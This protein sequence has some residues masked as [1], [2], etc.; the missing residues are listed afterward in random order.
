MTNLAY[1]ML[2]FVSDSQNLLQF[3]GQISFLKYTFNFGD[4]IFSYTLIFLGIQFQTYV[5][6]I[7]RSF[8]MFHENQN[9]LKNIF[10]IWQHASKNKI[11]KYL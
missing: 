10:L 6:N 11:M 9:S 1:I 2:L 4:L 3:T 8:S 7:V 5:H